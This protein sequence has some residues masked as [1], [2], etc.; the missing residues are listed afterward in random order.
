MSVEIEPAP[1]WT[2]EAPCRDRLDEF[3]PSHP[4]EPGSQIV[5]DARRLCLTRCSFAR[6]CLERCYDPLSRFTILTGAAGRQP[7]PDRQTIAR[8]VD[9][10]ADG[11]W[12]G[13]V[14]RERRAVRHLPV[15]QRIA[16]LLLW[17]QTDPLGHA[18]EPEAGLAASAATA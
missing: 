14:P 15:D 4:D 10:S 2:E 8:T 1:E 12:G 18:H 13:T 16:V 5:D 7:G 6:E 11:I 17:V 3:F 9:A